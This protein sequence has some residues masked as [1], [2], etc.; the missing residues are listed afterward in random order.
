MY[1]LF[2]NSKEKKK[3]EIYR[4]LLFS[5]G[6]KTKFEIMKKVGLSKST[7]FRNFHELNNDLSVVF[8]KNIKLIRTEEGTI[9][10]V[11]KGNISKVYSFEML[12]I[13]YSSKSTLFKVF[14]GLLEENSVTI[15]K[16]AQKLN[17]STPLVYNQISRLKKLFSKFSIKIQVS[18]SIEIIGNEIGIRFFYYFMLNSLVRTI[19]NDYLFNKDLKNYASIIKISKELKIRKSLSKSQLV[20]LKTIEGIFILRIKYTQNTM[21]INVAFLEDIS[22][23][24]DEKYLLPIEISSNS[25]KVLEIESRYFC[26]CIRGLIFNIDTKENREKI[27]RN[28]QNSDLAISEITTS[29]LDKLF[30]DYNC[31]YDEKIYNESYYILLIANIYMKHI[32]I[33]FSEYYINNFIY[34]EF[35]DKKN[36]K[37]MEKELIIWINESIRQEDLL[38]D[39]QVVTQYAHF[40][41]FILDLNS[42]PK[43][44]SI[45][46]QYMSNFFSGKTIEKGIRNIYN[47]KMVNFVEDPYEADILIS[48]TFELESENQLFFY[49][50][51]IYK[52]ENWDKLFI[53]IT[54]Q[55]SKDRFN[56]NC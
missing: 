3:L 49:F 12:R 20:S 50:N 44:T 27:A 51:G 2:V 34:S 7:F 31:S 25:E 35:V 54:E 1:D 36:F 42:F 32:N 39:S 55:I 13:Y 18:N 19:D 21:P 56:F 22:F 30:F 52:Q 4:L 47:E 48:D 8:K 43:P 38:I 28:Y 23:F 11:R 15:E 14:R 29:T 33:D 16:L 6:K 9:V 26:F 17:M 45:C 24:Y 41:I 5:S 46:I 37:K 10:V 40:L 53:F